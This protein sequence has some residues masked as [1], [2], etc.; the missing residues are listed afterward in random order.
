MAMAVPAHMSVAHFGA[1]I[2]SLQKAFLKVTATPAQGKVVADK[3]PWQELIGKIL[4]ASQTP[5]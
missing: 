5:T 2:E 4:A 1:I 3:Q